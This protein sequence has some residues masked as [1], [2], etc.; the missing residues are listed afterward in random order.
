VI[1]KLAKIV[2]FCLCISQGYAQLPSSAFT[3]PSSLS[4]GGIIATSTGPGSIFLNHSG[5]SN[6]NSFGVSLSVERRFGLSDLNSINFSVAKRL[7]DNSVIS[8]GVGSYGLD[9]LNQQLFLIS[10]ARK[11]SQ[12]LDL[13]VAFDLGRIDA[14][15]FGTKNQF[16]VE[17][18]S[19]F[20]LTNEISLG[21]IVKN[22]VSGSINERLNTGSLIALG[23]SFRLDQKVSLY[24]D[25]LR[26]DWDRWDVRAG[27]SYELHERIQFGL[28]TSTGTNT[29]NF[30]FRINIQDSLSLDFATYRHRTLGLTPSI[31]LV[32]DK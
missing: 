23:T 12:K 21:L 13:S 20:K 6:I 2:T 3:T 9:A 4:K 19:Q 5:L 18:G 26:N 24:V 31:G 25:V 15:E 8:F 11:L 14:D 28:G 32:Y 30:G 10:F 16:T 7:D 17:V 22:P 27:L 29:I 1:K